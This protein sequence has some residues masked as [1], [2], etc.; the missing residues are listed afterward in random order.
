M[1]RHGGWSWGPQPQRLVD[2]VIAALPSLI[3][4]RLAELAHHGAP[5]VEITEPVRIAV[6]L[7]LADLLAGRFDP[8]PQAAITVDPLPEPSRARAPRRQRPPGVR[9]RR[10]AW[11]T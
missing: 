10:R 11:T 6:S 3:A 5:D 9:T 2:Q 7:R 4:G 1:V 8:V